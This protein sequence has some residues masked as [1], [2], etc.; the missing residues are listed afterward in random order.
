MTCAAIANLVPNP[1]I[2]NPL[3]NSQWDADSHGCRGFPRIFRVASRTIRAH[4]C[5]D[6]WWYTRAGL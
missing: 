4:P 6:A 5:P 2:V 1:C 3:R